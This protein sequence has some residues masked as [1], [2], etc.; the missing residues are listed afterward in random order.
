MYQSRPLVDARTIA[1]IARQ[2]IQSANGHNSHFV[3]PSSLASLS[4][5]KRP[6]EWSHGTV[7]GPLRCQSGYRTRGPC[8]HQYGKQY[9]LSSVA[10]T[11]WSV[12]ESHCVDW[13]VRMVEHGA[14]FGLC[15]AH[16]LCDGS[17]K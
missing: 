3:G 4:S 9:T 7:G 16:T 12:F 10:G 8:A 14:P 5:R 15:A 6:F 2:T 17:Q 11:Q 13:Q 1:Q